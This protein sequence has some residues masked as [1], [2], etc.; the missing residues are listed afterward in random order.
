[1]Q[2]P[3]LVRQVKYLST[4]SSWRGPRGTTTA[5]YRPELLNGLAPLTVLAVQVNATI[6]TMPQT[7]TASPSY[8]L[9][10]RGKGNVPAWFPTH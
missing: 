1:M 2:R 8:D 6:Q 5:A 9:A 4:T 7:L 10:N 3:S